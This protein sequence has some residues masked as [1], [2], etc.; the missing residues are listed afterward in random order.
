MLF[1]ATWMHLAIVIPSEVRQRK[2]NITWY[3]LYVDS[4]KRYKWTY[5]QNRN[6]VADIE[7]KL[8]VT[9]E[10]VGSNKVGGWGWHTHTTLYE[11]ATPVARWQRIHLQFSS[12]RRCRFGPWVGKIP[13]RRAW[14]RTLKNPTDRGSWQ[15]RVYRFTKSARLLVWW[16]IWPRPMQ[17]LESE[18]AGV[19]LNWD[20]IYLKGLRDRATVTTM[21]DGD[22]TTLT[23]CPCLALSIIFFLLPFWAESITILYYT[24]TYKNQKFVKSTL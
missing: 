12:H 7:N 15:A 16:W 10:W 2:R 5:L 3:C 9:R 11:M 20:F 6:R 19:H 24:L 21:Q 23:F 22:F 18:E 4:W 14:Q 17:E 1:A 8:T 13:W